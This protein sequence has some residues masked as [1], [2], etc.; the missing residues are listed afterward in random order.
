LVDIFKSVS[1]KPSST[2]NTTV[3]TVPLADSGAV[4]PVPPTTTIIKSIIISNI[5]GSTVNTKVRMLDSSNSNLEILLHDANLGHPEVKEIL[6]HPI[7]LEQADQIKIQAA[8][9]DAVEILL[10]IMEIT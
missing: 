4:P 1:L 2:S 5:S 7:V 9:G 6:T 8:T 10:S 3:Y